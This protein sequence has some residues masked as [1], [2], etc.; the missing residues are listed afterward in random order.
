MEVAD[1]SNDCTKCGRHYT[2]RRS[3]VRHLRYECITTPSEQC[4]YCPKLCK[5]H[6]NLIKHIARIHPGEP[7]P[8]K[9]V[10]RSRFI[11]DSEY[12]APE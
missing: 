9:R 10:V 2:H 5:L 8:L 11:Q 6:C 3:L 12:I 7:I 4:P 1:T